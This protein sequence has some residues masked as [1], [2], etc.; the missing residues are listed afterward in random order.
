MDELNDMLNP[1][2]YFRISR[3]FY[4]SVDSVS[5]IHDYFGNRLMLQL[6]PETDKE[7]IV[8]REKVSDFKNWLGK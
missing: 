4:I 5:Q 6:K 2:K 7:A 8:S 3:S 1:D